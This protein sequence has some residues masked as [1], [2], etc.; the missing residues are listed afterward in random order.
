MFLL[1]L[2]LTYL[3][4]DGGLSQP[5]AKMS[6]EGGIETRTCCMM[7]H[8][9]TNWTIPAIHKT[10]NTAAGMLGKAKSKTPVTNHDDRIDNKKQNNPGSKG[11]KLNQLNLFKNE[12]QNYNWWSAFSLHDQWRNWLTEWYWN[13]PHI[14]S[15]IW[16]KMQTWTFC[17]QTSVLSQI[18]TRKKVFSTEWL[19]NLH[20][21]DHIMSSVHEVKGKLATFNIKLF[22]T[23]PVLAPFD[24][25]A[26]CLCISVSLYDQIL[27]KV[28]MAEKHLW[29]GQADGKSLGL[30]G[31]VKLLK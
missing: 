22:N 31:L 29:V 8:C 15:F 27:N 4:R 16:S 20:T 25:G 30:K 10:K 28:T 9:S 2:S 7:V 19:G 6:Q 5:Q 12:Y 24:T 17:S 3:Q 1:V 18:Q 13:R 11:V 26:T 23:E 14:W 21:S